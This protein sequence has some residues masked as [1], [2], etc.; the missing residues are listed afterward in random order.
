MNASESQWRITEDRLQKLADLLYWQWRMRLAAWRG[1]RVEL[2]VTCQQV[3]DRTTAYIKSLR[4]VLTVPYTIENRSTVVCERLGIRCIP[5]SGKRLSPP[6]S[7][8][9]KIAAKP[10][11]LSRKLYP[12]RPKGFPGNNIGFDVSSKKH[13]PSGLPPAPVI[14]SQ[15]TGRGRG[16]LGRTEPLPTCRPPRFSYEEVFYSGTMIR[17]P[18]HERGATATPSPAMSSRGRGSGRGGSQQKSPTET[19]EHGQFVARGGRFID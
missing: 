14:P 13:V 3:E 16:I 4:Y 15:G 11:G 19:T 12:A 6:S 9:K 1:N 7:P 17:R 10:R 8:T 5:Q 2:T 18:G